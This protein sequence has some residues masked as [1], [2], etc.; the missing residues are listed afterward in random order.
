MRAFAPST[1][2]PSIQTFIA[3]LPAGARS[4]ARR[5]EQP[6]AEHLPRARRRSARSAP[7]RRSRRAAGR[8][9]GSAPRSPPGP[10]STRRAC[11]ATP[12][13]RTRSIS[14]ASSR[15]STS[16][17]AVAVQR[18]VVRA[19]Q[20]SGA[21]ARYSLPIA[22][23][24]AGI[25]LPTRGA[26]RRKPVALLLVEHVQPPGARAGQEDRLAERPR[27]AAL[28]HR[29]RC[30]DQRLALEHAEP[31]R[32]QRD[33]GPIAAERVALDQAAPRRATRAAGARSTSAARARARA[34]TRRAP[35][36]LLVQ[37]EEQLER[38]VDRPREVGLARHS[39]SH[40]SERCS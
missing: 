40:Y 25:S 38:L 23:A 22:V 4:R 31:E 1:I 16:V 26:A 17:A 36:A 6:R 35:P 33:A 12:L 9:S 27:R 10:G 5:L 39:T 2:S 21:N 29:P 8:R 28:E 32:D 24:C 13:A 15:G 37:V 18:L 7:R 20:S 19:A 14:R 3:F 11:S 34:R 30:L